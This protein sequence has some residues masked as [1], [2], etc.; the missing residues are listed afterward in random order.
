MGSETECQE[1]CKYQRQGKCT[2]ERADL[3]AP[4]HG[5][6]C[7]EHIFDDEEIVHN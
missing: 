7:C 6:V 1:S 2:L 3:L 5:A 4:I